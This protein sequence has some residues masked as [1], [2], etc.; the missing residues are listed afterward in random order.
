MPCS[1]TPWTNGTSKFA[2][3]EITGTF[4]FRSISSL[5]VSGPFQHTKFQYRRLTPIA[6][7]QAFWA[8]YQQ[9]SAGRVFYVTDNLS[10]GRAVYL[11]STEPCVAIESSPRFFNNCYRLNCLGS[12]NLLQYFSERLARFTRAVESVERTTS[13]VV[14]ENLNSFTVMVGV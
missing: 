12:N 1:K 9:V 3:N 6:P 10:S 7:A 5:K 8:F 14:L 2:T 13:G 4:F 11:D